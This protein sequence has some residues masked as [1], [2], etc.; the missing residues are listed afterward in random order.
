MLDTTAALKALK[1]LG[2]WCSALARIT[3]LMPSMSTAMARSRMPRRCHPARY[4]PSHVLIFELLANVRNGSKADT[5]P[6]SSTVSRYLTLTKL[7]APAVFDWF[8]VNSNGC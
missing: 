2:N 5:K 3:T 6:N 8:N 4:F 7:F 1:R